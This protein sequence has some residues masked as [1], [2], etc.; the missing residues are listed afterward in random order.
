LFKDH[1]GT[2]VRKKE[3]GISVLSSL[4]KLVILHDALFL[5]LHDKTEV[6]YLILGVVLFLYFFLFIFGSEFSSRSR[7]FCLENYILYCDGKRKVSNN[8]YAS[9]IQQ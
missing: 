1:E 9:T 7:R 2:G 8:E 4:R 5:L 3:K 6:V